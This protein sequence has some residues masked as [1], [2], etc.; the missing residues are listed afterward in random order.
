MVSTRLITIF[1]SVSSVGGVVR[2]R[3]PAAAARAHDEEA[4]EFLPEQW[5][6][7]R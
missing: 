3:R 2:I 1:I 7:G 4:P 6:L 5:P